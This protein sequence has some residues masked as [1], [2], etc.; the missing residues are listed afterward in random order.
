M[1]EPPRSPTAL[2]ADYRVLDFGRLLPSGV[3]TFQ[4]AALGADVIKVERPPA[5]DHLR[6][7]PP[8]IRSRGD[9]HLEINRNKRSVALDFGTEAGQETALR[10]ART[11]DVVVESSR[12]GVYR[13]LGLD[14]N[15]VRAVNPAV[16]YA[17]FTGFGQFG[18]YSALP[19]HGLSADAF[20]SVLAASLAT[21]NP[22]GALPDS[23][24]SAGAWAAGMYGAFAITAALLARRG[25]GEGH[26]IDIAQADAA[27]AFM[28]RDI[29][30]SANGV[31]T[32]EGS[33]RFL[34]PRYDSYTCADGNDIL[35]T[36][37]ESKLWNAFCH[38][39]GRPDLSAPP[40]A[41]AVLP[42][43]PDAGLHRELT[44]IF[45]SRTRAEWMKLSVER[46]LGMCPVN[47]AADLVTDPHAAQRHMVRTQDH[48][49]G[50]SVT[51]TGYPV[52]VDARFA[53]LRPAPEFGQHTEEVLAE[54][55]E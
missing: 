19:A 41:P 48:P 14:Y 22:D 35:L 13:R 4:L 43:G 24:T 10:L 20:G 29:A 54:C 9:M 5:G 2:L 8:S 30:L 52:V 15:A 42:Y 7:T 21:C 47:S 27:A 16:V 32:R 50:G 12:P 33:F 31:G 23:Y 34:G 37:T 39:A 6:T 53:D 36:A 3:A 51:L 55:G 18:P 46:H 38:A 40:D 44:A 49:L 11:A 28:F 45:R 17:S 26:H 1:S 25:S